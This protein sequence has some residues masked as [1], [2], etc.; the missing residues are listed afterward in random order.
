MRIVLAALLAPVAVPVW[1]PLGNF[2][3]RAQPA[4]DA[5]AT[6]LERRFDQAPLVLTVQGADVLIENVAP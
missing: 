1:F 6:P 5:P 2:T 4:Q 3:L